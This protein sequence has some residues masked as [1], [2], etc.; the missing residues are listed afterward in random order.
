[1]YVLEYYIAE[2]WPKQG[3]FCNKWPKQSH[4]GQNRA[5]AWQNRDTAPR[6]NIVSERFRGTHVAKCE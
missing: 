2:F 1:V 4:N 3:H 5:T 6:V